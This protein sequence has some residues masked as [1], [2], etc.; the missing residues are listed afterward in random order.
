[1]SCKECNGDGVIHAFDDFYRLCDCDALGAIRADER[2]KVLREVKAAVQALADDRR[3][4]RDASAPGSQARD[5]HAA[6]WAAFEDAVRVIAALSSADNADSTREVTTETDA[7]GL[8]THWLADERVRTHTVEE[9]GDCG[10]C[11]GSAGGQ[12]R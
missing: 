1:M 12:G 10:W 2:A 9:S 3:E 4:T 8:V 5:I 6:K 11:A 7:I